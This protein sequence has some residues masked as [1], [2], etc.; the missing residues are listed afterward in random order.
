MASPRRPR[1]NRPDDAPVRAL[2][3]LRVSTGDQV[4]SGAGLDAQRAAL[5][6]R[7]AL[8]GWQLEIVADE[9]LSAKNVD[10]RPELVA[11]LARLD[12]GDVDV[13]VAAKLD[14]VSR[15][16]RDFAGLLDRARD[17]GWRLVLLDLGIDTSSPAGEFVS[18]TL[19]SAAQYERRIIGQ[20]TREGLAA[21][22]AQGV[23]LGRPT[24]LPADVV[25]R[26]V[27]EHR[28][29]TSWSA[30]ARALEAD[31]VPT[32]QGGA[33]WYPATVR[34]V[35]QGQAAAALASA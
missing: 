14:R 9:G 16:V 17:N 18:N 11:A 21:K 22:R 23:R 13:L 6:A 34:K 4:E 31:G 33:R 29:G 20:R 2:G 3:Y 1:H 15:S 8:E 26:I 25:T 24:S 10:G 28:A 19:A 32:A 12:A 27:T 5:I 30:I 7:A 35:A